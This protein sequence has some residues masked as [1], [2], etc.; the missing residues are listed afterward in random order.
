MKTQTN[1]LAVQRLLSVI[2]GTSQLGTGETALPYCQY[3]H[4][5][6]PCPHASQNQSS[7][8]EGQQSRH[9]LSSHLYMKL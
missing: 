7:G 9:Q 5:K 8:R 1:Q 2:A 3:R 4:E 6:Y